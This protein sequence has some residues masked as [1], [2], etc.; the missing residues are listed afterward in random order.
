MKRKWRQRQ[1]IQTGT[2]KENTNEIVD[3]EYETNNKKGTQENGCGNGYCGDAV[4]LDETTFSHFEPEKRGLFSLF[5]TFSASLPVK[6]ISV[7]HML[8][9]VLL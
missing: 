4:D 5:G 9:T 8:L 1:N 3:R 2:E 6:E 7:E